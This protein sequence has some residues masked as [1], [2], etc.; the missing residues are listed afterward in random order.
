MPAIAADSAPAPSIE[1][2]FKDA[3]IDKAVLSPNGRY[4]AATA[5]KLGALQLT[6]MDLE[7]K[8]AKVVAGYTE[9][10]IHKFGWINN[11]RLFFSVIDRSSHQN[12][13]YGGLYTVDRHGGKTTVVVATPWDR[14]VRSYL[15]WDSTPYHMEFVEAA[16]DGSRNILAIGYYTDYDKRPF[17]VDSVKGTQIE[18]PF[19]VSGLPRGFFFDSHDQLRVVVTHLAKDG[20]TTV[21]W[22]RDNSTAPWR[23]LSEHSTHASPFEVVAVDDDALYVSAPAG[24]RLGLYRY[25]VINNKL[26]A[27]V[28]S[29]KDVDVNDGLITDSTGQMAIGVR[30]ASEP[31]HTLWFDEKMAALQAGIDRINPGM[32]NVIAPGEPKAPLLVYSY[33]S[34]NPGRYMRYDPKTKR[35]EALIARMP[36]IDPK[37]MSEQIV[38]DYSARDGLPIMAYLTLPK[39]QPA[40]ALPLIVLPHG[41]PSARD[42]WGFSPDVQFLA[43]RGYA[44]LQPQFRGSIGFGSEH[45]RK[46]ARQWGLSMQDDLT[47]GVN[48]LVE[49]GVVDRHRVC[50]MGASYGGYAAMMGLVRDPDLY[51]CGIDLLGVTDLDYL[52]KTERWK[53]N[54]AIRYDSIMRVAD[55]DTMHEQIVATSP[56]KQVARIKAPVFMAY[57]ER[58]TRVLIDNGTDMRDALKAAGKTYEWM[59]FTNEEHGFAFEENRIK[60]YTAIDAFLRKYNPTGPVH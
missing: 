33:S 14:K 25:D 46:G 27:L 15:E 35:L 12:S 1:Y 49:Q 38:F 5:R 43:S 9:L 40:K 26:G 31:P 50:I 7:T 60:L 11:D 48:N 18:I 29:H 2:F 32:V 24:T 57:G 42:Y 52:L 53:D 10:D 23:K 28:A 21:V 47:D 41:G 58:D 39:G 6:V 4:L 3:D 20:K 56:L 36:W 59:S 44:V 51:R 54:E 13:S 19:K 55:P 8:E 30:I 45:Y 17:L 37:Q 16:H 34:T 22:Y